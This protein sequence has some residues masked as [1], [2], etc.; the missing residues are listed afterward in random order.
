MAEYSRSEAKAWLRSLSGYL[1]IVTTPY[2]ADG[3]IDVEGLRRNVDLSLQ[4]PGV[5]GTLRWVQLSGVLDP[6]P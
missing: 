1:L 6:H 5:T 2:S 3:S 4:I